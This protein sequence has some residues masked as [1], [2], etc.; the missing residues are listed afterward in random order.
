MIKNSKCVRTALL[1]I[2]ISS[3]TFA[4]SPQQSILVYVWGPVN[5]RVLRVVQITVDPR[6]H[7]IQEALIYDNLGDDRPDPASFIE[8]VSRVGSIAAVSTDSGE[9]RYV[10]DEKH[11]SG[12]ISFIPEPH[13]IRVTRDYA[14]SD[15]TIRFKEDR[16]GYSAE[17]NGTLDYDLKVED[18]GITFDFGEQVR[19]FEFSGGTYKAVLLKNGPWRAEGIV[20][21]QSPGHYII[22]MPPYGDPGEFSHRIEVW[23]D[24]ASRGTLRS[25]AINSYLLPAGTFDFIFP[26][27]A[28]T[29]QE[30]FQQA[31]AGE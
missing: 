1:A 24:K 22:E 23:T 16:R 12:T 25:A 29:P 17:S 13:D 2:T 28:P 15:V 31:A 20:S 14:E 19:V 6:S 7:L 3:Q 10:L 26:F 4:V 5:N 21:S 30:V 11:R 9:L 27:F 18:A 8:S